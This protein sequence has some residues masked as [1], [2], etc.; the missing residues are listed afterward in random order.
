[1]AV[2]LE[3]VHTGVNSLELQQ[4]TSSPVSLE[5]AGFSGEITPRQVE[6]ALRNI[7]RPAVLPAVISS[8]SNADNAASIASF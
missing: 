2:L 1:M 7:L 4:W 5:S 3:E 8:Q 6:L